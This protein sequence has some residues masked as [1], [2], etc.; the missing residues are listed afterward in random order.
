MDRHQE[1]VPRLARFPADAPELPSLGTLLDEARR[2]RL[3]V[4]VAVT[5]HDD[6]TSR[7]L[8]KRRHD[9]KAALRTLAFSLKALESGYR[10]DDEKA[11]AKIDA[12]AKAVQVLERESELALAILKPE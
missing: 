10:F 6:E 2:A 3:D 1:P 12:I 11:T 7:A 4:V 5:S 9:V 8:A